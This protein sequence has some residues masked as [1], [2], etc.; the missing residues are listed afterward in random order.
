MAGG[1]SASVLDAS[2][3]KPLLKLRFAPATHHKVRR[4]TGGG[5]GED[6]CTTALPLYL[7]LDYNCTTTLLPLYYYYT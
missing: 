2:S 7:L 4:A 5:E 1:Y 6:C 3:G